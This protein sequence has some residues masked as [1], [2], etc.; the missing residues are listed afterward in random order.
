MIM[1]LVSWCKIVYFF[2]ISNVL[3][4][5]NYKIILSW[6]HWNI[7]MERFYSIWSCPLMSKFLYPSLSDIYV[8]DD[9]YCQS[10][11]TGSSSPKDINSFWMLKIRVLLLATSYKM[12]PFH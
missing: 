1:S 6:I 7:F 9:R 11:S 12:C 5:D 8:Q 2:V 10:H 3:I 4:N